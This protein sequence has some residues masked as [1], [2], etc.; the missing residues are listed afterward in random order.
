MLSRRQTAINIFFLLFVFPHRPVESG[1]PCLIVCSELAEGSHQH[2]L[3]V[4]DDAGHKI[5]QNEEGDWTDFD[6]FKRRSVEIATERL[7]ANFVE[8]PPGK[9]DLK[10][11]SSANDETINALIAE[12]WGK[13]CPDDILDGKKWSLLRRSKSATP[14]SA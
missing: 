1:E 2:V 6:V 13:A 7:H 11:I 14:I 8:R 9:W 5:L 10:T 4:F 3:G 12:G